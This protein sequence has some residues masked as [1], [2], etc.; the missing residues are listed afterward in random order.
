M[1]HLHFRR[2]RRFDRLIRRLKNDDEGQFRPRPKLAGALRRLWAH[3]KTVFQFRSFST[4]SRRPTKPPLGVSVRPS[5]AFVPPPAL[6]PPTMSSPL[7]SVRRP[8]SLLI[9]S[10]IGMGIVS[11]C[12]TEEAPEA[13]VARVGDHYLRQDQLDRRLRGLA[14]TL[15][16]AQAR[17]QVINQWVTRTL[18]LREAKR[19]NLKED[20]SVQRQ[21]RKQ[22]R[23]TLVTAMTNRLYE[24][25][26]V[27]PSKDA[28]RRYFEQHREQLRLREPYVRVR[29]LSTKQVDSAQTARQ[30]LRSAE[31]PAR[32][33]VWT[34]VVRRFAADT[35]RA[36]SL[37]GKFMPSGRL[38]SLLPYSAEQVA[39]LQAG[40]VG[41]IVEDGERYYLIELVERVP[42]GADPKLAWVRDEIRE[43]LRIDRR[44]QMYARE[45]QRL[46]N[47]ARADDALEIPDAR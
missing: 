46:R 41:P 37:S 45:V 40:E 24:N 28:I 12:T 20:S 19:M 21:L 32:D 34:A 11:A 44:K 5:D 13:Y 18:L 8:L 47:R 35:A 9:V 31:P 17:E 26:E 36:T 33:S 23:S 22:R 27:T 39:T 1:D 29:I 3:P 38:P 10:L 15:D 25:A 30:R 43:R 7:C 2:Q 4:V 16:S 42:E 14:P 6:P